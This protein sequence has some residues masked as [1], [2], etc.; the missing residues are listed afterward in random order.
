MTH[1]KTI[2]LLAATLAAAALPA[3]A[4]MS[5]WYVGLGF[6]QSKTDSALVTNRESTLNPATNV[7]SSFD[8]KDSAWKATLGYRFTDLISI[9]GNYADYGSVKLDTTFNVPEGITG[10]GG[11]FTDRSVKGY[12]LDLVLTAPFYERFAVFGRVGFFRA[13]TKATATLSGETIFSDGDPSRSRT[14]T[15][16]ENIAKFGVGFDWYVWKNAALRLEWERLT[17]VGKKIE[18]GVSG[19]TGEADMDLWTIGAIWRF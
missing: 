5:P 4:Q 9:E 17:D 13:E 7:T 2:H 10:L 11:V 16:R 18:S 12:G 14:N 1:K 8:D 6:G 15:S 3:A 19:T